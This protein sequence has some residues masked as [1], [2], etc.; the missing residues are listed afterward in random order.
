LN[1]IAGRIGRRAVL[2]PVDD[3][4]AI[5]AAENAGPLT[6]GFLL[7]RQDPALPRRLADKA[8]LG[9]ACRSLGLPQPE[10]RL[11]CSREEVVE[12]VTTLGLPVM[13]KWAKPWGLEHGSGLRST[14][15]AHSAGEVL[16]LFARARPG[17]SPLLLQ[18]YVPPSPGADWFFHGYFDE[19]A[20]C[21]FGGAGRKERAHPPAAGLTTLGRW[22]RNPTVEAI[23]QRL[24]A[25]VGYRG[26]LD[27]DFRYDAAA[28]VYHVVDLNPR[29]GA[30]FRLFASGEGL[31]LVRALHLD[32]TGRKVP[33]CSP[34]VG[35]TYLVENYDLVPSLR[36]RG[37]L[38]RWLRSVGGADEL[39]WFA[40]DDVAPFAAMTARSLGRGLGRLARG[41]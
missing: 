39:A 2:I 13:A 17:G 9:E 35:R 14:V 31:D 25:Q 34:A 28:G 4:G 33:S 15:L 27:I 16:A 6:A 5:F 32:L 3:Q 24:A 38:G 30:Q 11:P 23:A 1:A 36:G 8:A 22:L 29:L 10:C 26:V 40:A 7:P 21:L 18:R 20:T 37:G 19:G 41:R 12:A